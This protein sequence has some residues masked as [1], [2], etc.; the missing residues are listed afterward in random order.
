MPGMLMS[1]HLLAAPHG[2]EKQ[3]RLISS[4]GHPRKCCAHY[5]DPL[6]V[7][8][9]GPRSIGFSVSLHA[10]CRSLSRQRNCLRKRR[11]W[12]EAM[13]RWTISGSGQWKLWVNSPSL[14]TITLRCQMWMQLQVVSWLGGQCRLEKCSGML[15]SALP[16]VRPDTA[17]Y[18][19]RTVS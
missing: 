15:P 14:Q 16:H 10:G 2:R 4:W 13:V 1:L 18:L 19:I 6:T 9:V 12:R 11:T 7:P 3:S 5:N 17:P 8:H